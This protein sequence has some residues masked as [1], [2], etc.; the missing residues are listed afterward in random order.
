MWRAT[1]IHRECLYCMIVQLYF[2]LTFIQTLILE[3]QN[4]CN[5]S[6]RTWAGVVILS[7]VSHVLCSPLQM[8]SVSVPGLLSCQNTTRD[9]K[10]VSCLWDTEISKYINH[11]FLTMQ[12]LKL[13]FCL[14]ITFL[15]SPCMQLYEAQ[16]WDFIY[17]FSQTNTVEKHLHQIHTMFEQLRAQF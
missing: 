17:N 10:I 12:Q 7:A 8:V 3:I 5:V 14:T 4:K 1:K 16:R 13:M 11:L 15:D 2:V 6:R 9:V